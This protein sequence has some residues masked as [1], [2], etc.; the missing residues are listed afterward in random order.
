M[1]LLKFLYL[2]QNTTLSNNNVKIKMLRLVRACV[3]A[4]ADVSERKDEDSRC[5]ESKDEDSRGDEDDILGLIL[6]AFATRGLYCMQR[7][8]QT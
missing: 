1:I 8:S 5:F 6:M 4:S 3:D 7:R 2:P